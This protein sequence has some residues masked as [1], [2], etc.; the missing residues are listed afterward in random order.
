MKAAIHLGPN[1]LTNSEIYKNTNFEEIES[2]FN[3]TQKLI[4]EHSEDILNVKWLESSSPSW[5]ES[6]L[7]H[8]QAIKRAKAKVFV[9]ADSVLSLG[10]M[11]DSKDAIAR[12]E[13]QGEGLKM[14]LSYQ[15][16]VGIDGE[17][18]EFG[19]DISQGFSSL[20][21]YS[22]RD[23][24]RFGEKEHRTGS[25]SCQCS[26]TLFGQKERM[27]RIVSRMHKRSK[28]TR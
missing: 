25:S 2:P 19:W 26:M 12:W 11:N 4:M 13:G 22:P 9:Y 5:T 1:Y 16:A 3:I 23:Q 17:A 18:I 21:I 27:M 15:E 6:V 8:D 24:K 7:S 14:Y 20:A 28:N 10:Q